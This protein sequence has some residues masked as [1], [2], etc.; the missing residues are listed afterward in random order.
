MLRALEIESVRKLNNRKELGAK[1]LEVTVTSK[2]TR[3]D[4]ITLTVE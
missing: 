2:M 4:R 3:L 1:H